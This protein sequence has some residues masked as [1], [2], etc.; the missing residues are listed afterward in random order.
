MT[1][2]ALRME[3]RGAHLRTGG[4]GGADKAFAKGTTS[5]FGRTIY[6]PWRG[7]NYIIEADDV[8]ICDRLDNWR[9]ALAIAQNHHPAWSR[10][11]KGAR[12]LLARNT[13]QVLGDDLRSP[14]DY[15]IGYTP[16]GRGAG[17]TGQ[18][19]RVAKSFGVPVLDLGLECWYDK[20]RE[21]WLPI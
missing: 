15:V 2:I 17:G 10:C 11:S 14:S 18:A 16:H 8:V 4:A 3:E 20:F 13:Y 21:G 9:E 5:P 7:F 19:Y 1:D 6:I 12:A